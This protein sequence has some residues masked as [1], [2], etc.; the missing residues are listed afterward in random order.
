MNRGIDVTTKFSFTYG[1]DKKHVF[2]EKP[3]NIVCKSVKDNVPCVYGTKC[4]FTHYADEVQPNDCAFGCNCTLI[5]YKE[6]HLKNKNM[7]KICMFIHPKETISNW[8][9]RNGFNES[10]MQRPIKDP[11]VFKCTRMC[12][13]VLEKIPCT[14]GEECT[15]A[16][17]PEEL[18][19]TPCNFGCYCKHIR[20]EGEEY[21]NNETE[22][23]CIFLHPDESLINFEF[24]ALRSLAKPKKEKETCENSL[25]LVPE[26]VQ[27]VPEVVQVIPEVNQVT[28]EVNQVIPEVKDKIFLTVHHSM[29]VEML[30]MLLKSGKTNI[31]LNIY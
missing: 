3:K 26:V 14:K 30:D 29:A 12:I 16:H 10:L 21:L 11:E 8:L 9:S 6:E 13:S 25:E 4:I 24:R 19:T 7:K 20:K 18:K 22:K 23:I 27:V 17:S 1:V 5:K 2:T 31:E 15:Y 28:P